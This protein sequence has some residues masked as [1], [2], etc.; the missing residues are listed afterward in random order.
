MNFRS[1]HKSNH[2][3]AQTHCNLPTNSAPVH[4]AAS[5]QRRERRNEFSLITQNPI[6]SMHKYV[7]WK[8]TYPLSVHQFITQQVS[9]GGKRRNG[10]SLITQNP[11]MGMHKHV[12]SKATY[13][14][15]VYQFTTQQVAK[16]GK[17]GTIFHSVRKI[18]SWVCTNMFIQRQLN[19]FLSTSSQHSKWVKEVKGTNFHS[20]HKIQSWVCTNMFI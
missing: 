12:H 20:S 15:I 3:Y 1:S 16:G 10:F 11:I 8:A 18:Q 7:H 9:K 19:Y 2:E 13:R 17:E 5:G 6:M 14:L 4:K